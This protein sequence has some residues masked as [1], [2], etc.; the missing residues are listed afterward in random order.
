MSGVPM[1]PADWGPGASSQPKP[2]PQSSPTPTVGLK[3]LLQP[4]GITRMGRCR[5]AAAARPTQLSRL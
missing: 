3:S 1:V 2:H 4:G 5:A